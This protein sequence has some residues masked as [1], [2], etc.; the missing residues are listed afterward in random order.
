MGHDLG[1]GSLEKVPPPRA[2]PQAILRLQPGPPRFDLS[3]VN[4]GIFTTAAYQ[5]RNGDSLGANTDLLIQRMGREGMGQVLFQHVH[6]PLHRRLGAVAKQSVG[7]LGQ[8]HAAFDMQ[9][10]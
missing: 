2:Q 1:M 9:K 6:E 4:N 7:Y 5:E 3:W 10:F 8:H